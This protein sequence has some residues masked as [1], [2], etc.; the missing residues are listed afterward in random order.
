MLIVQRGPI[1]VKL[2]DFGIAASRSAALKKTYVAPE[3]RTGLYTHL[4]DLWS[5]E[6]IFLKLVA[7]LP[8]ASKTGSR[9]W[10]GRLRDR[11]EIILLS[12]AY[13]FI[14]SLL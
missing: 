8:P 13:L 9:E 4:V 11:L 14:H 3:V 6:V 7:G 10:P 5:L 12:P 2:T 1:H